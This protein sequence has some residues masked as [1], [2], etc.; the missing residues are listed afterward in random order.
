MKHTCV[1]CK[2]EFKLYYNFRRH[3]QTKQHS[4]KSNTNLSK[5]DLEALDFNRQKLL[6]SLRR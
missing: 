4:K 2:I 3:L 1:D 5:R 6:E